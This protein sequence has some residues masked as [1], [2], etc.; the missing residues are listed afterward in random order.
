[1]ADSRAASGGAGAGVGRAPST[2]PART[3]PKPR[4]IPTVKSSPRIDTARTSAASTSTKPRPIPTVKGS[5]RIV[6][7]S[8]A[9]TAGL[10]YVI[11]VERT[12][13]ISAIRAKKSK[14]AIAVHTTASVTIDAPASGDGVSSGRRNA[15]IGT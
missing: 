5:P 4:P 3:R 6:T 7:P 15:A 13:P 9:A 14:N 8:T 11:A 1:R 12:G 10:T 2:D